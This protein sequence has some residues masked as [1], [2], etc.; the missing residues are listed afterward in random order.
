MIYNIGKY[1]KYYLKL[2]LFI[3]IHLFFLFKVIKGKRIIKN[4]L[5]N[6][7]NNLNN[8]DE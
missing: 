5:N 7:I 4:K 8:N 6:K 1:F 2:N 3:Y